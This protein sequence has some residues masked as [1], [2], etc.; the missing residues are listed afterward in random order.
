VAAIGVLLLE[1]RLEHSHSLKDKRQV[2]HSLKTRLRE[3][4]NVAVSEIDFQDTWQR[5]MVAAVTVASA[6]EPAARMLES[7]ERDAAE[8]LGGQLVSA[9]VEWLD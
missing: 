6:R 7:A 1:L 9:S 5:S 2:V 8:L 3:R 4:F